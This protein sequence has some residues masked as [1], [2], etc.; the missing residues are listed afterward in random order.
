MVRY[1]IT[2][3]LGA[4]LI[5][6]IQPIISRAILPWFG[7][8]PSVWTTCML[9]FQV[10]LVAGYGYAHF[11]SRKLSARNFT[12]LHFALLAIALLFLPIT[13]SEFWK[14]IAGEEPTLRLMLLLLVT[15]SLP[16]LL[17]SASSPVLP[18]VVPRAISS[19]P[20]QAIRPLQCRLSLGIIEL[21]ISGRTHSLGT[22]A[23]QFLVH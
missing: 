15:I 10:M 12:I 13:P 3:F 23:V 7:G 22:P 19:N 5:F 14:P 18:I 17:L 2:I 20:I 16:Y 1:G 4:F 6:Q 21:P 9:F 11:V 8:S